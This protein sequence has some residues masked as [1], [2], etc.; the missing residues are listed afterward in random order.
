[1]KNWKRKK[2]KIV[3][4]KLKRKTRQLTGDHTGLYLVNIVF[5]DGRTL[6]D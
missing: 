3:F 4:K 5:D 6:S 2:T 1:M